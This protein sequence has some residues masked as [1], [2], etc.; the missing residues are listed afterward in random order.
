MSYK[1]ERNDRVAVVSI[2]SDKGNGGDLRVSASVPYVWS[3]QNV[4]YPYVQFDILSSSVDKIRLQPLSLGGGGTE[5]PVMDIGAGRHR[6]RDKLISAAAT[7][8]DNIRMQAVFS[9][10]F[11]LKGYVDII[12]IFTNLDGIPWDWIYDE[13]K[14]I[15]LCEAFGVGVTFPNEKIKDALHGKKQSSPRVDSLGGYTALIIGSWRPDVGAPL[16]RLPDLHVKMKKLV[17][18]VFRGQTAIGSDH[19]TVREL[20]ALITAEAPRARL[21]CLSG[22]FTRE[23]FVCSDGIFDSGQ[24]SQALQVARKPVFGA[25]PLVVLNGC[26]SGGDGVAPDPARSYDSFAKCFILNGA[27]ACVFTSQDVRVSQAYDFV[28]E[29][30]VHCLAPGITLGRALRQTRLTIQKQVDEDSLVWAAYHLLGDPEFVVVRRGRAEG[31][32]AKLK[33]SLTSE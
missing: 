24:L 8:A 11:S 12:Q 7:I 1:T 33:K 28:L 14:K 9:F 32:S 20:G 10:L 31:R 4:H 13:R 19:Y 18:G 15:F 16:T 26:R 3:L 29:L 21:I 2:V 6:S 5:I 23:G 27:A 30:L 22:H 25:H 17:K